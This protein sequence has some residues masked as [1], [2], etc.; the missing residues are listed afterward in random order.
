MKGDHLL[1]FQK[2]IIIAGVLVAFHAELWRLHFNRVTRKVR[3]L[4]I[5]LN[6]EEGRILACCYPER[7][8][9]DRQD[10][11]DK[12]N[13]LQHLDAGQ[14]LVSSRL[15]G[16]LRLIWSQ[17]QF[18]CYTYEQEVRSSRSENVHRLKHPDRRQLS[19]HLHHLAQEPNAIHR[20][21]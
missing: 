21:K 1:A 12:F 19:S 3:V 4:L 17:A 5:G 6:Q 18:T 8:L 20:H 15:R 9:S 7:G 10:A 14:R 13:V 16:A 2:R 11:H